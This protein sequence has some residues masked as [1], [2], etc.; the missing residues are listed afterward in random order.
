M[1]RRYK[2]PLFNILLMNHHVDD[3]NHQTLLYDHLVG[4]DKINRERVC[5]KWK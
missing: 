4:Y 2:I 3:H 5:L 1:W